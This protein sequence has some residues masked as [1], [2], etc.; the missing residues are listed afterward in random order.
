MQG[1]AGNFVKTLA[2]LLMIATAGAAQ[3][4][5][6]PFSLV[7]FQVESGAIAKPLAEAGDAKRGEAIVRDRT[8]SSCVLCHVV[9]DP[10]KRPMG[11]IAPPLAG[12]G[13]R[14]GEGQLRVRLVDSTLVNP[15][16]VMPPYYRVHDL[17]QVAPAWRDKPILNAQQ[18]EDIVAWLLTL[19]D[20]AQ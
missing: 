11:N 12:V 7:R 19:K 2:G 14:L 6:P 18:I 20:A 5:S 3:A 17:H 8:L 9:P 1:S 15:D 4:Q 13:S 16:S 10:D